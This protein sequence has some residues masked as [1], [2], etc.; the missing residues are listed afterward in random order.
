MRLLVGKDIFISHAAKD[1]P[2]VDLFVDLLQTGADISSSVIFCSS[3]EGLGIP[4][5][6][7]FIEYLKGQLGS[8]KVVICVISENYLASRFC[9]CELGASWILAHNILPLIVPPINISDI[10]GILTGV[11]VH[12]IIDKDGLNE[13]IQELN[14]KL[15]VNSFNFPRWE[16]K[17]NTFLTHLP[18]ILK[19]LPEPEVISL[20]KY[21]EL[22]KNYS[23]STII[24]EELYEKVDKQS[25]LIEEIKKAKDKASIDTIIMSH[26]NDSEKFDALLKHVNA[27]LS[28]LPNIV[29][30]FLFQR[31]I[32]EYSII[33][34]PFKDR[35]TFEE[36]KSARAND[37]IVSNENNYFEI[38]TADPKVYRAKKAIEEL[39][40]FIDSAKV[41]FGEAFELENDFRF[42][43]KNR[44][45]WDKYIDR[46]IWY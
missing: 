7:N 37:Y 45:F 39:A 36:A 40:A 23:K 5:G 17:R 2:L 42:S 11:Q 22:E 33:I 35:D 30:Y 9:L 13:F 44:R 24:L 15:S 27:C 26:L 41:E 28:D 12:K 20:Q 43:I 38:N 34:D 8:P 31:F 18:D 3:L 14:I 10:K 25:K 32:G 6:K 29:V 16:A 4:S 21:Q 1:K 46:K 19:E